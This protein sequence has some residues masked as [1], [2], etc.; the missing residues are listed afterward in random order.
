MAYTFKQEKVAS[1]V[2]SKFGANQDKTL[3]IAGVDGAINDADVIVGGINQMLSI[4][5]LQND[6]DPKNM[7]RMVKQ[8]VQ[9]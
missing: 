9:S 7:V 6:Y 5:G 4:V 2:I 8:S 1:V 3:T